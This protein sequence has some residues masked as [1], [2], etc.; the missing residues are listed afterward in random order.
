M[1][2]SEKLDRLLQYSTEM[3]DEVKEMKQSLKII[4]RRL[5]LIENR[6]SSI[7][8]W[9]SVDNAHLHWPPTKVA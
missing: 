8:P 6:L 5:T 3:K 4:D 7:E 2:D 9:I 1:T